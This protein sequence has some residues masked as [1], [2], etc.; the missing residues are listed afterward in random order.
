MPSLIRPTSSFIPLLIR[1]VGICLLMQVNPVA[2]AKASGE[3]TNRTKTNKV[4]FACR[5]GQGKQI[6]LLDQGATLQYSF[7]SIA[8]SE[9]VLTVP[10]EKASTYQWAGVGRSMY[11]SINIPN[12]NTTY[13]V[14]W[15]V[16]RLV[17]GQPV[18]AGVDVEINDKHAATVQ[19][20]AKGITNG[21]IGVDLKPTQF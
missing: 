7:G 8:K 9:I 19:C 13:R 2:P 16:D 20:W 14:F 1:M 11:Y 6:K 15:S 5:T 18:T 3:I 17:Q 4:L 21:L 10:R 12:R